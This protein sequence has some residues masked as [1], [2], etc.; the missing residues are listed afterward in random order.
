[1][2]LCT[3]LPKCISQQ[4]LFPTVVVLLIV[5][6]VIRYILITLLNLTDLGAVWD[7]FQ[8]VHGIAE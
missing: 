5:H 1:M 7:A 8:C 4:V 3:I 2:K 6:V